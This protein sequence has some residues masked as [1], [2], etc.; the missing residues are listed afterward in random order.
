MPFSKKHRPKWVVLGIWLLLT[1]AAGYAFLRSG[2]PVTKAPEAIR[3]GILHLGPWGPLAFIVAYSVRALFFIPAS[4]LTAAAGLVWGPAG[5]II[6]TIVG[7]NLSSTFAFYLARLL[8]RQ[9][10][11]SHDNRFLHGVNKHLK[12]HGFMTVLVL[13]LVYAPFDVVNYGCGLTSMRFLPFAA[14]T[15]LGVL[16]GVVTFVYFGSGLLDPR[17]L[18]IS[19]VLF[20][21][22]LILARVVQRRQG[23]QEILKAA[24]TD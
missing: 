3:D 21:L 1:G 6:Y 8:G 22:T 13:R 19:A 16:P 9:W 2:I 7:E 17:N 15:F 23:A 4:I 11:K 5:G 14:A 24:K 12:K 20:V 18:V 10:F